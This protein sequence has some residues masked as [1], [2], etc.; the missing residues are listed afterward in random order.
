MILLSDPAYAPFS[1][2]ALVLV[3]L[4][5]LEL[6]TALIGLSASGAIDHMIGMN[7]HADG[8]HG[9]GLHGDSAHAGNAHGP[10]TGALDWLNAGRVPLLVLVMVLLALFAVAGFGLQ[11]GTG[12]MAGAPLPQG[13]AIPLALL[14]AVPTARWVSRGLALMVP[15]DETY[16]VSEDDFIG[17]TAVVTVGPVCSGAIARGRLRDRHGNTHFP[18]LVPSVPGT[19]IT[20]GTV[21]LVVGR[22]G[23]ELTVIPATGL[24]ADAESER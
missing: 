13:A 7:G 23:G 18:K 5:G 24:L 14:V 8:L 10:W 20:E 16:V 9:D 2:A 4:V 21:V 17:R 22:Q 12:A 19:V 1:I 11:A 3:G 6:I 15:R